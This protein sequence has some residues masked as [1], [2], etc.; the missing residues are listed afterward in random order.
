[1]CSAPFVP[2][3]AVHLSDLT[4]IDEGNAT[5][6]TREERRLVNLEKVEL[7]AR[8]IKQALRGQTKLYSFAPL[9][10]VQALLVKVI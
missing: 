5:H 7:M 8:S 1:M 9:I 2:F 4:F 10:S 6:L 3:M